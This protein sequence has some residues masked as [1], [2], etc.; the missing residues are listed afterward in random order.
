M[1]QLNGNGREH[2][3]EV[4]YNLGI[5][6]IF[7]KGIGGI[8]VFIALFRKSHPE[9]TVTMQILLNVLID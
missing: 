2:N 5:G 7:E 3:D 9:D 1:M 8:F 6:F 4:D